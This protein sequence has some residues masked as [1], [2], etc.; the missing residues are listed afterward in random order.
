MR[1]TALLIIAVA[2][3]AT[4]TGL[5][6]QPAARASESPDVALKTALNRALVDG[7]PADAIQQYQDIAARYRTTA[8]AVAAQALIAAAETYQKLGSPQAPR[9]YEQIIREYPEQRDAVSTAR[10]RVGASSAADGVVN[11]QLWTG[12]KVDTDGRV[13]PDGRYLSYVDWSTGDL[14]L[15]DFTT[16]EDR[17]LTAQGTI[18]RNDEDFAE[19]SVVSPDGTRVAYSWND[20]KTGMYSLRVVS[21]S[22]RDASTPRILFD[23]ADVAWIA[24]YDWSRDGAW[25]AVAL[26]RT[27]RTSQIGLL[28]TTKGTLTVLRTLDWRATSRVLFSP[29][30]RYVAYDRTVGDDSKSDVFIMSVDGTHETAIA[31]HPANDE[32]I[33]WSPA[34]STL[35]FSS[36]RGGR[37]S[38]FSVAIADGRATAP[39][40]MV[41]SDFARAGSLGVTKAGALVYGLKTGARTVHVVEIDFTTGKLV[42]SPVP[43]VETYVSNAIQPDWSKDGKSMVFV[44]ERSRNVNGVSILTMAD[45]SVRDLPPL[46]LYPSL[47]RWA[48]DGSI[49]IFGR[50]DKGRQGLQRVDP[51]TGVVSTI[52]SESAEGN[53]R[54]NHAWTP[55]GKQ[56]VYTRIKDNSTTMLLRDMTSNQERVLSRGD[57]V[58]AVSVSPD[59]RE[60]A[61]I[62]DD[63]TRKTSTLIVTPLGGAGAGRTVVQGTMPGLLR[64]AQWLPDGQRIAYLRSDSGTGAFD[65]WVV[66]ATGTTPIKTDLKVT[67]LTKV[68][69]DGRHVAFVAGQNSWEVWMLDNFLPKK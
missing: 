63:K 4:H 31:P 38:L 5:M 14:A 62:L 48:P 24:P 28:S 42:S 25:L 47:P 46:L 10:M 36:D 66:S 21:T 59:G 51:A 54:Y 26:Q 45:K 1:R 33:G 2:V 60:L 29:D 40:V 18:A 57:D 53:V 16:G 35:L 27:D 32:L 30:G 9:V 43:A 17:R 19:E 6:Q 49:S 67:G 64:Q 69:P 3:T 44:S 11:R 7:N 50:T 37:P 23:N 65:L 52:V 34:G 13:S 8:P 20:G 22:A 55:D 58:R 41:K 68:A 12:P 56:L 61:Y 15:H 39:P